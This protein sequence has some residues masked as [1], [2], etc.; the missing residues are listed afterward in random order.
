MEQASGKTLYI[1]F[2]KSAFKHEVTKED[3][4]FAFDNKLL[5]RPVVGEEEKNLLIGFDRALNPLEILYNEIDE[6]SVNVFHAMPCRKAWLKL[7]NV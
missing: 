5:D 4:R 1:E 6:K 3:I 7:V 2:N